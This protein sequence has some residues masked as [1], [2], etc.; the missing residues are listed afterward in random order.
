MNKEQA[1]KLLCEENYYSTNDLRYNR[2]NGIMMTREDYAEFLRIKDRLVGEGAE[3]A[4][5]IALRSFNSKNI[6]YIKSTQLLSAYNEYL[7]IITSD[8]E[9]KHSLLF[10]RNAEDL[11][12]SRF[13]SEIEGSLHIENVPTTRKRIAEICKNSALKDTNDIIIQNMV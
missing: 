7:R 3:I 10:T 5:P 2:K 9:T 6:F 4:V 12:L 8:Y 13:F 1:L 11:M